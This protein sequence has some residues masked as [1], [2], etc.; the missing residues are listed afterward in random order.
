MAEYTKMEEDCS[1]SAIKRSS[2]SIL[3]EM[4]LIS[5]PASLSYVSQMLVEIIN[6][7]FIGH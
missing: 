4:L 1:L 5:I 3:K 6:L 2:F 7:V